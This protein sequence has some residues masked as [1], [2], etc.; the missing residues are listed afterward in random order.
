VI[1]SF[2]RQLIGNSCVDGRCRI[3]C[4]SL[5]GIVFDRFERGLDRLDTRPM[6]L[7]CPGF[8]PVIRIFGLVSGPAQISRHNLN[9]FCLLLEIIVRGFG[10]CS[11]EPDYSVPIALQIRLW[12][13]LSILLPGG[14]PNVGRASSISYPRRSAARSNGGARIPKSTSPLPIATRMLAGSAFEC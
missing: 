9:R 8:V 3:G 7:I 6:V 5:W 11:H 12:N 4:C 10:S 1:V 13:N 2:V 14:I